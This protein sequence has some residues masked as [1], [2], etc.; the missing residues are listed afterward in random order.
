MEAPGQTDKEK[1]HWQRLTAL[2][3]NNCL[4]CLDKDYLPREHL[5]F[6]VIVQQL[7]AARA[8][9]AS[10]VVLSGG[11]PTMHP[12]FLKIVTT[13]VGLGFS[14]VQCVS[15]GRRFAY[16]TFAEAAL[17][18]GISE[19]TISVHGHDAALHDSLTSVPGSFAQSL[20]G[21]RNLVGRCVLSVDLVLT[22]ALMPRLRTAL[23][24]LVSLGVREFDL[25]YPVPFGSAWRNREQQ[26]WRPEEFA[27]V[28]ADVLRWGQGEGLTLWTNRVPPPA[29]EGL[30]ELIQD[31]AKIFDEVNG[32]REPFRALLETGT[33]LPCKGERC[34][35]CWMRGFCGYLD[36]VL[37]PG[38]GGCTPPGRPFC[39]QGSALP[40]VEGP[41]LPP[42]ASRDADL[43]AR[44]FIDWCW[45]EKSLRCKACAR[46]QD[47][48]GLN[49]RDVRRHGFAIL[50]PGGIN[51]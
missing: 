9:G 44:Y 17:A 21:I 10:R 42:P 37:A 35:W 45:H 15:N 19:V 8:G 22:R 27:A 4:F 25:L 14:W 26:F 46:F 28:L 29:L 40:L 31:P 5:A 49:I 20:R 38:D 11:E 3:N 36:A 13:A 7:Q 48:A 24:L 39:L 30:E 32:R 12:D 51:G 16:P 34:S 50:Q 43:H 23:E 18:A 47:C 1:K 6:D 33:P 41:D 2:C